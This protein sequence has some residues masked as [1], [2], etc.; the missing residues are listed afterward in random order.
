MSER[1]S[2]LTTQIFEIVPVKPRQPRNRRWLLPAVGVIFPAAVVVFELSTRFCAQALFDPMPTPWHA[3]AV[4]AAPA[5]NLLIW[6]RLYSGKDEG[7]KWLSAC[8]GASI[9][10]GGFYALLFAPLLPLA[11]LLIMLYGLGLLPL[12]PIAAFCSALL[13]RRS[14]AKVSA[15]HNY[16]RHFWSGL[17][18][19]VALLLA[20]DIS[21]TATRY[22]LQLATSSEPQEASAAFGSCAISA[23]RTFSFG[24]ATTRRPNPPA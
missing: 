10:I 4:G 17:A 21:P 12:A 24:C 16:A 1:R 18:A 23:T 20:L 22:G 9:A 7:S 13:L 15:P 5:C 19:G 14:F 2:K 6:L 8:S 3:L 11:I